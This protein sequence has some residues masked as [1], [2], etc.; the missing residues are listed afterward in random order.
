MQSS[1]DILGELQLAVQRTAAN[2]NNDK[3]TRELARRALDAIRQTT[4]DLN[5]DEPLVRGAAENRVEQVFRP[6]PKPTDS[7]QQ[8]VQGWWQR[9]ARDSGTGAGGQ[10]TL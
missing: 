6:E 10:G 7:P 1:N 2:R 4:Q 9:A 3:E 8:V 5:S